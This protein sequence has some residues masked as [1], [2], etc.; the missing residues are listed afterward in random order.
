MDSLG[1]TTQVHHLPTRALVTS[2]VPPYLSASVNFSKLLSLQD[3]GLSRLDFLHER[4]LSDQRQSRRV[5]MGYS[6]RAYEG[7]FAFS[8]PRHSSTA[9]SAVRPRSARHPLV[10]SH[11]LPRLLSGAHQLTGAIGLLHR[12]ASILFLQS[13]DPRRVHRA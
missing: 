13:H 2:I 11:G 9:S 7:S 3:Y 1:S 4:K 12:R 5:H 8:F 10:Q 6:E